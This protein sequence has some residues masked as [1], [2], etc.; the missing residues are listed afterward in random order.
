[1]SCRLAQIS[2]PNR[3]RGMRLDCRHSHLGSLICSEFQQPAKAIAGSEN[4][5]AWLRAAAAL[6]PPYLT[7]D[8][9]KGYE[10]STKS[11]CFLIDLF[12]RA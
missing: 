7:G 3:W 9:P 12:K 4:T 8:S 11:K 6:A 5:A 1:M 2:G 10:P